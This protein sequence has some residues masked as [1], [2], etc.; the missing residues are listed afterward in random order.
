MV[1]TRVQVGL[2]NHIEDLSVAARSGTRLGTSRCPIIR[3]GRSTARSD[4]HET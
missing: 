3:R 2:K 4:V 1:L